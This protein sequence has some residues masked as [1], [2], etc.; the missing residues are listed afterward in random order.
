MG[1]LGSSNAKLKEYGARYSDGRDDS[2]HILQAYVGGAD[3]AGDDTAEYAFVLR[4]RSA[5]SPY[6]PATSVIPAW[7]SIAN[8]TAHDGPASTIF[9][10]KILQIFYSPFGPATSLIPAWTATAASGVWQSVRPPI[11]HAVSAADETAAWAAY[12]ATASRSVHH[13]HLTRGSPRASHHAGTQGRE[14]AALRSLLSLVLP[15]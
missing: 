15:F 6:G 10:Q 9:D 14:R 7:T 11:E 1:L 13:H 3:A 4:A 5:G 2:K 8:S 12:A